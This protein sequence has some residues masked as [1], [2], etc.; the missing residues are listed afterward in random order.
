MNSSILTTQNQSNGFLK[1]FETACP[2]KTTAIT[3]PRPHWPFLYYT[4]N[5]K[6]YHNPIKQRSAY[7]EA[8]DAGEALL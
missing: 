1:P 6:L 5:G 7:D 8:S 3:K 4:E 2:L